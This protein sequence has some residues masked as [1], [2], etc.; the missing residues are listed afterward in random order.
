MAD[1]LG[2][3]LTK[4]KGW[5]FAVGMA[6]TAIWFFRALDFAPFNKMADEWLVLAASAAV[7]G[8]TATVLSVVSWLWPRIMV[9]GQWLGSRAQMTYRRLTP[10]TQIK[11]LTANEKDALAWM[12]VNNQGADGLIVPPFL[13]LVEA[14]LLIPQSPGRRHREQALLISESAKKNRDAILAALGNQPSTKGDLAGL[15]PPWRRRSARYG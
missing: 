9:A 14:G 7:F 13:G 4:P 3:W 10:L 5:P 2:E 12:L 15:E 1:W 8:F 6:G 11:R